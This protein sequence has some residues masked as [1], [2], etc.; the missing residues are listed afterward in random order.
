MKSWVRESFG[1]QRTEMGR[2]VNATAIV[3]GP[4]IAAE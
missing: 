3:K 1:D 4:G 2:V